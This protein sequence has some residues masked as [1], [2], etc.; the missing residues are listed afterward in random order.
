MSMCGCRKIVLKCPI[1]LGFCTVETC[2]KAS[3]ISIDS[4]N[5][6]EEIPL[7]E[8]ILLIFILV[9]FYSIIPNNAIFLYLLKLRR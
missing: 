6:G 1:A 2:G 5:E 4:E 8:S 9:N 7:L 3:K